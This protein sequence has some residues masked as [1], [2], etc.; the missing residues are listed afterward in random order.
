MPNIT[1][2]EIEEAIAE[3]LEADGSQGSIVTDK[4]L[5]KSNQDLSRLLKGKADNDEWRGWL[6]TWVGVPSQVD[7]GD[8]ITLTTYKF[9]CKFFHFY[10][11]DYKE[12][13]TTEMSFK[14]AIFAANEALNA[15]RHLGFTANWQPVR[16]Q[17]L[18]SEGD[19]DVEDIG[20][21]SVSQPCHVAEFTIDVTAT[22]VY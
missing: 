6:L 11:N 13:L 20:G 2:E 3:I 17:S 9:A 8:C 14:R 21:G 10:L 15:V 1:P 22:N 4:R 12:N 16:H 19:F 5:A 18:Q 7:E